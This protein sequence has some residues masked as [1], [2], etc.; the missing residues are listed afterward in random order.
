ML[1]F[2]ICKAILVSLFALEK[3][4][5][6]VCFKSNLASNKLKYLIRFQAIF[7][8]FTKYFYFHGTQRLTRPLWYSGR[9]GRVN[10]CKD[11]NIKI[12]GAT[13][14][15]ELNVKNF[16]GSSPSN[17][18]PTIKI[19]GTTSPKELKVKNFTGSSPFKFNSNNN[20]NN[21]LEHIITY[22]KSLGFLIKLKSMLRTMLTT[23]YRNTIK[24]KW[25][26]KL[27]WIMAQKALLSSRKLEQKPLLPVENPFGIF[28]TKFFWK[29]PSGIGTGKSVWKRL[30]GKVAAGSFWCILDL[31]FLHLP[32]S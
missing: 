2:L 18:I 8:V 1:T 20:N 16:T 6:H 19:K 21:W 24:I 5:K 9:R 15:E 11:M 27:S 25:F 12:K 4:S 29:L 28:K 32:Q 17:L 7:S 14:P 3:F 10:Y 13:S 30:M 23:G 31:T 26:Q 22:L